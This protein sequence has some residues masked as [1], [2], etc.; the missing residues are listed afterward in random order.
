MLVCSLVLCF[1][2][3]AV[4]FVLCY[5]CGGSA[6]D[7]ACSVVRHE[8]NGAGAGHLGSDVPAWI[9]VGRWRP[10]L[11]A[12]CLPWMQLYKRRCRPAI[13]KNV[14]SCSAGCTGSL[15]GWT[16]V[17]QAGQIRS[18]VVLVLQRV[19]NVPKAVYKGQRLCIVDFS[20]PLGMRVAGCARLCGFP[21]NSRK[22]H[23]VHLCREA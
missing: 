16:K 2:G 5:P 22:V 4:N 13:A 20:C 11:G 9:D 21:C 17:L 15:A 8:L 23:H 19:C 12:I 7:R 14:L 18:S 10:Y 1:E 6:E 3:G